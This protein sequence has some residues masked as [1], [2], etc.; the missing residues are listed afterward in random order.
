MKYR[1]KLVKVSQVLTFHISFNLFSVCEKNGKNVRF[2]LYQ[3]IKVQ[4]TKVKD[5]N[6]YLTNVWLHFKLIN[7]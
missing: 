7:Y 2:S 1:Y 3:I 4:I 5:E 6:I